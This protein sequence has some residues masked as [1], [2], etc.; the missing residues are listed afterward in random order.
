[1]TSKFFFCYLDR[2]R[3]MLQAAV[4]FENH[5]L[6]CSATSLFLHAPN[7]GFKTLFWPSQLADDWPHVRSLYPSRGT[8]IGFCRI[9]A[10]MQS[11]SSSSGT[12]RSAKAQKFHRL[13]LWFTG[14]TWFRSHTHIL[15]D[16]FSSM[17]STEHTYKTYSDIGPWWSLYNKFIAS[18]PFPFFKGDFDDRDAVCQ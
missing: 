15:L 3:S 6:D 5:R 16:S 4:Q 11:A 10:L 1:M 7:G 13:W 2:S 8:F 14:T 17:I 12:Q 18:D 9:W